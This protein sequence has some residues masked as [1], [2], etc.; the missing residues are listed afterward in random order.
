MT[1][2]SRNEEKAHDKGCR[3]TGLQV[4]G[5]SGKSLRL[6]ANTSGYPVFGIKSETRNGCN[7]PCH[8]LVAF[9]KFGQAL[10]IPGLEVRHVDGNRLNFLPENI[11][12]GT[13]ADNMQDIP[14]EVRMQKALKATAA[15]RKHDRKA[16]KSF[17]AECKSYPLTMKQFGITSTG[18]L[19]YVLNGRPVK[20]RA[21]FAQQQTA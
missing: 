17:Y 15:I 10:F 2:F 6:R 18:T 5:P 7:V 21:K 12:L 4:I 20:M 1:A 13:H 3:A 11:A 19:H 9:Q 8:R 16:V 14:A